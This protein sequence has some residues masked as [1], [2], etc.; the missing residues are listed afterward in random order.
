MG[1]YGP[2]GDCG[3]GCCEGCMV[4]GYE[5]DEFGPFRLCCNP[6]DEGSQEYGAL[7]GLSLNINQIDQVTVIVGDEAGVI[8]Y[9][10]FQ[11]PDYPDLADW[12]EAGG[13]LILPYLCFSNATV[14][15][16]RNALS[17]AIGSSIRINSEVQCVTDDN[18]MVY[19]GILNAELPVM[20]G[21]TEF[22]HP[23]CL[24]EI[25]GG[26]PAITTDDL[27]WSVGPGCSDMCIAA[28]EKIG[29]GYITML[30]FGVRFGPPQTRNCR[31]WHNFFHLPELL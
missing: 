18:N 15:N 11:P 28:I 14:T 9:Q 8:F 17:D 29:D 3:T 6:E 21:V 19:Q 2:Q 25:T 20:D 31:Y 22:W 27:T 5:D 1:W 30:G 23:A 16:G 13:R 10:P 4:L 7:D 24:A 26:T 12:V